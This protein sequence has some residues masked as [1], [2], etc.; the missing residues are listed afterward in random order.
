MLNNGE[1]FLSLLKNDIQCE[2]EHIMLSPECGMANQ[3]QTQICAVHERRHETCGVA[4]C[5]FSHRRR[6]LRP[7]RGKSEEHLSYAA[8]TAI[9]TSSPL[10]IRESVDS[11]GPPPC[12]KTTVYG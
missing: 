3:L 8:F 5:F 11:H 2:A 4:S 6:W 1:C 7:H 9:Y 10:P 12:F